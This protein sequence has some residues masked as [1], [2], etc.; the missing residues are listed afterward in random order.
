MLCAL[1]HERNINMLWKIV[2]LQTQ[3]LFSLGNRYFELHFKIL[4]EVAVSPER[5]FPS[6]VIALKLLLGFALWTRIDT[7]IPILVESGS[8]FPRSGRR[9]DAANRRT[10]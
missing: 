6:Q 9:V 10:R 7:L 4:V 3:S 2:C 5:S 8:I 1:S